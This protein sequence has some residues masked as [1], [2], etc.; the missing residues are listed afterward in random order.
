[1]AIFLLAQKLENIMQKV[2][3][4][5]EMFNITWQDPTLFLLILQRALKS[6]LR[7]IFLQYLAWICI[8]QKRR[9][10]HLE[11]FF[12]SFKALAFVNSSSTI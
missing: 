11:H 6:L 3:F 5:R 7:D 8:D 12:C 1:L 9:S 10:V 2:K 4:S